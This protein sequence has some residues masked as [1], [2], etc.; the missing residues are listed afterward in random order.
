M[1][2]AAGIGSGVSLYEGTATSIA[3]TESWG[4]GPIGGTSPTSIVTR[5]AGG[6]VAQHINLTTSSTIRTNNPF[7]P[8]SGDVLVA[9]VRPTFNLYRAQADRD[10]VLIQQDPNL[11]NKVRAVMMGALQNPPPGSFAALLSAAEKAELMALDPL[12]A[13]PRAP[14]PPSRYARVRRSEVDP[15]CGCARGAGDGVQVVTGTELVRALSQGT[16]TT[17]TD[18]MT[19]PLSRVGALIGGALGVPLPVPDL[20][21]TRT[22]TTTTTIESRSV[23]TRQFSDSILME[24]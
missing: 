17:S 18:T 21:R 3:A 2:A 16:A 11:E 4:L 1:T 23:R 20:T 12:L 6:G 13:D 19:L 14:L 24:Y 7:G 8:G 22:E 15:G 10:A 9:I 5:E